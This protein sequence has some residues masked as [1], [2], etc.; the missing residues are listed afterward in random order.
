MYPTGVCHT[1]IFSTE[2][3]SVCA[4][5]SVSDVIV[6]TVKLGFSTHVFIKVLLIESPCVLEYGEHLK[7]GALKLRPSNIYHLCCVERFVASW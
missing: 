6:S 3:E 1:T 4:C 7:I 2:G 5:M